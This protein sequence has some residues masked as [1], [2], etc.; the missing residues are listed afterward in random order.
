MRWAR[1]LGLDLSGFPN[2]ALFYQ[3]VSSNA[4]VEAVRHAE[5]LPV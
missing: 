2:L 1:A 4:G 3:R 5:G